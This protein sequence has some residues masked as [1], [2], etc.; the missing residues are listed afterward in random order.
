MPQQNNNPLSHRPAPTMPSQRESIPA[1]DLK[2]S[3][4]SQPPPSS[5]IQLRFS[6]SESFIDDVER[7]FHSE[8]NFNQS[9]S[10]LTMT[11]GASF[12]SSSSQSTTKASPVQ[13]I[14][15]QTSIYHQ[16]PVLIKPGKK[17]EGYG[18]SYSETFMYDSDDY[19]DTECGDA[20]DQASELHTTRSLDSNPYLNWDGTMRSQQVQQSHLSQ[21]SQ[22]ST[23]PTSRDSTTTIPTPTTSFDDLVVLRPPGSFHLARP[24]RHLPC[25]TATR[26]DALALRAS[27]TLLFSKYTESASIQLALLTRMERMMY[28]EQQKPG[29]TEDSVAESLEACVRRL[30]DW[31]VKSRD[32][33][34]ATGEWSGV[35]E[36]ENE[37]VE[38]MVRAAER[39][40][41]HV[42]RRGCRCRPEWEGL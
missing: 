26:E 40:V 11:P 29:A 4:E 38:W 34:I 14:Q 24:Q 5:N 35:V 21:Q 7:Q 6:F 32:E 20:E 31:L 27:A 2:S 1:R 18:F 8:N 13:P 25:T 17:R 16:P 37:W 42:R 19:P 39:G 9:F 41:L 23:R 10:G 33:R 12:S 15:P 28:L 3:Q 30:R 36:H 22:S